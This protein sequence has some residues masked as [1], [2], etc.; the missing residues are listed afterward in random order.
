MKV[1][2]VNKSN[3]PLPKYA[4]PGDSGMDLMADFS[5]GIDEKFLFFS[6]FDEERQ[7]LLIFEG[8]RALVPTNIFTA[9]PEGYEIQIRSRSGLALKSGVF[10]T[11]GVGTIDSGYRNSYGVILTNLGDDVF[12]IS[13]GDKIAQA[14]LVKVE[15]IEWNEV[16]KLDETERGLTGFGD[17]G[18]KT[19]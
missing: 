4:K 9:I 18:I 7:T 3:N 14:V 13:Q 10:V 16:E 17:S 11:N 19:K 5:N 2:I 1:E 8:G 15:K 6:D 12:E